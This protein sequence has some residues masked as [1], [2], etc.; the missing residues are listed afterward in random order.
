MNDESKK[1]WKAWGSKIGFAILS[2]S[3]ILGTVWILVVGHVDGYIDGRIEKHHKEEERIIRIGIIIEDGQQWY[4][5]PDG[6]PHT[7][8]HNE[9]GSRLWYNGKEMQKIYK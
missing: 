8:I 3:G 4:V 5:G 7:V 2:S 9:E 6:K 1:Y